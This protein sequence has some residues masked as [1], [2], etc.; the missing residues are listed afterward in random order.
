MVNGEWKEQVLAIYHLPFTV[1]GFSVPVACRIFTARV[2][3]AARVGRADDG[4]LL[5]G[6]L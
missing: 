4:V 2:E 5:V 3:S 1:Y 6:G